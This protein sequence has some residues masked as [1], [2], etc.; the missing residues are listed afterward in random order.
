MLTGPRGYHKVEPH[1]PVDKRPGGC[2]KVGM[3][4]QFDTAVDIQLFKH[5]RE[6][7]IFIV[8]PARPALMLCSYGRSGL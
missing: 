1:K 2:V 6:A 3:L 7:A 8:C 4:R 5:G